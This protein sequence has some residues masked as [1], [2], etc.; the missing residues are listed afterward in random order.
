DLG[1]LL[2]GLFN[3][4]TRGGGRTRQ[5]AGPRRGDDLETELH[6][7]FLDSV[8]GITTSVNITSDTACSTCNGTGAAPGTS[9]VI[10]STCG[11]RGVTDDNQGL[12][13][14]S[15]PCRTCSGTGMRIETPCKTCRGT[16]V[17]RRP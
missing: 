6:L 13:S 4:T 5:P 12:F 9:P 14:F 3:R 1:D 15:Q 7:S 2:G 8:N 11:G 17:E 16:G 10:C